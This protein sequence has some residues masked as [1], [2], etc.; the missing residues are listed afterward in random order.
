MQKEEFE[1]SWNSDV[2]KDITK[3]HTFIAQNV[4]MEL[5]NDTVRGIYGAIEPLRWTPE[6]FS[7]EQSLLHRKEVFRYIKYKKY[8]ILYCVEQNSV[9]ILHIFPV[10]QD[11]KKLKRK[12]K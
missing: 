11:P 10:R 3:I 4:S 5:A 9:H 1:L 6:R 7:R 2:R 12:F 8:K